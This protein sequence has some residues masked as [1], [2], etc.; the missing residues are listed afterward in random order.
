MQSLIWAGLA[1][2]VLILIV[3]FIPLGFTLRGKFIIILASFVFALAGIAAVS[4]TPLWQTGLIIL[5]L[6]FFAAYL[7]DQRM[8]K[9]MYQETA[10]LD[11]RMLK[12]EPEKKISNGLNRAL[13]EDSV[14][15][16][17]SL[18]YRDGDIENKINLKKINHKSE[19]LDEEISF[20]L[21]RDIGEFSGQTGEINETLNHLSAIKSQVEIDSKNELQRETN[22][23]SP[24][25]SYLSEI[26]SLLEME[27]EEQL[28]EP[29][30]LQEIHTLAPIG[31]EEEV[32]NLNNELPLH[33]LL[34]SE[35]EAASTSDDM[36]EEIVLEKNMVLK[37]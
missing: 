20:L 11:E 32:V 25:I 30:E 29:A 31:F 5:V 12:E 34:Q 9:V 3:S 6:V 28:K 15:D 10:M 24:D 17:V 8:G 1:I 23:Q 35:K 18:K 7:F 2:P 33:D 4:I 16:E 26:E 22:E 19:E 14:L 37:K 21:Q 36:L 27:S 13:K